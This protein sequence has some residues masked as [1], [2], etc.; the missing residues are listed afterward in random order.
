MPSRATTEP[1]RRYRL[2]R[3]NA[4]SGSL[5]VS[6]L[7]HLVLEPVDL[8]LD[9]LPGGA[10]GEPVE[11]PLPL[12]GGEHRAVGEPLEE[13]DLLFGGRMRAGAPGDT[14]EKRL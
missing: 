14:S 4:C 5:A 13:R 12:F 9:R 11:R 7:L 8:I 2:Y 10:G 6:P 1:Y 3:P